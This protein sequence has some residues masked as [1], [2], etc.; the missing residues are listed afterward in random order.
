MPKI[1]K[2]KVCQKKTGQDE[3]VKG[4]ALDA[5]DVVKER[6][7][8]VIIVVTAI[9]AV[10]AVYIA[11]SMYSSSVKDEAVAIEMKANNYYYGEVVKG[12]MSDEERLKKAIELYRESIDVT[13]TPTVLYNLGNSYYKLGDYDNAIKEYEAA[14]DKFGGNEEMTSLMYQKIAASHIRAGRSDKAFEALKELSKVKGGAFKDTALVLEARYLE[15]AGDT[16]KSLEKY[17]ELAAG[18]PSS[19]WSQEAA[20]KLSKPEAETEVKEEAEAEEKTEK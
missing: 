1:I 9:V 13:A 16:E 3:E 10:L 18:F 4:F 5:L 12:K 15:S 19:P 2:K 6:Q 17:V 20:S 8:Q 11:F 7:K 14:I